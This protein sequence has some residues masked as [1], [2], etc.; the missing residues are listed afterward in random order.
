MNRLSSM[1]GVLALSGVCALPAVAQETLAAPAA[2][3]E[4]LQ[5]GLAPNVLIRQHAQLNERGE[6][7]GSLSTISADGK[8]R[9]LPN[10]PI[11]LIQGG[12]ILVRVQTSPDGDFM[13]PQVRPG[14]Y[15]LAASNTRELIVLPILISGISAQATPI[16]LVT[17]SSIPA[18]RRQAVL[19]NLY[20]PQTAASAGW[21]PTPDQMIATPE[22][23]PTFVNPD[24][25]LQPN[26]MLLGRISAI[27]LMPGAMDMEG[28]MIRLTRQG[29]TIAEAPVASDGSFAIPGVTPG[30]VSVL[31]FGPQGFA[32]LG[33]RIVPSAQFGGMQSNAMETL[34]TMQAGP[35]S[36][37][38]I[39]IASPEDV[40]AAT[41]VPGDSFTDPL[42]AGQIG[43]GGLPGG[44]VPGG[45]G[46]GG[47]GGGFGGGAGGGGAGAG[48]GLGGIGA[49]G[50][51]AA[52]AA[53]VAGDDDPPFIPSDDSPD[54]T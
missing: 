27:G 14:I 13:F 44:G 5:A 23:A 33:V 8:M 22:A 43:P 49:I 19:A 4:M 48:G 29:E 50:G 30:P 10:L 28:M 31:V 35:A 17:A 1:F 34:V 32:A 46:F 39:E 51:L 11:S 42:A 40:V 6:L 25:S 16:N 7:L 38:N 12:R 41:Q 18:D 21:S 52:A 3:P 54:G 47:G 26:G 24:V 2:S 45:G 53:L 9:G 36:S 37:L 20:G 15:T